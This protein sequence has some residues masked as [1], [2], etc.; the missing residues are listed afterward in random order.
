MY[1]KALLRLEYRQRSFSRETND[2]HLFA[3]ASRMIEKS[4]DHDNELDLDIAVVIVSYKSAQL[5]ID[6]LRS[7]LA[8][9]STRGLR[10]RAVVVDNASGDLPSIAD[11]IARNR[12]S[13]WVTCVLAPKNGGFAYGN[14]LGI[15][16]AC[17]AKA[18][19]Y[20]YLLNP[21][22]RVRDGAIGTLI[23]FMEANREVGIAGSSFENLDGSEWM[24]AFRFPS[25]L[26][27]LNSGLE[28]GFVTRL[29]QRWVVP[30]QMTKS[31]QPTDWI[32]GASMMI[33]PS[34]IRATGGLDENYFLYFEETDFC[35][36]AIRAGFSTWYVP[37]S[38]VMHIMG[39]S[40]Q[41][42]DERLGKRRL[43]PY[44]F[45]SRRRYFAVTFGIN[46]AIAIDV[47][48]LL[49]QAFGWLKRLLLGRRKDSIPYFIS[50]LARHSV[51]RKRNRIFPAIRSPL[52]KE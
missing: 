41:V 3:L 25:L 37:D 12:W 48:A 49:A 11:A 44:W 9:Q 19:A 28:V 21:D 10:M 43:P 35:R 40:T 17:A 32:C 20:I 30:R 22:T 26:S 47:V 15:V 46:Y 4:S 27:E 2:Q 23:R 50:D 6:C 7:I 45:E 51:L 18:P 13:S 14:N 38:K 24:I 39:Q 16:H 29:L 42:T 8:D 5:T 1:Q 31:P 52:L 36:R 34:V 33:R